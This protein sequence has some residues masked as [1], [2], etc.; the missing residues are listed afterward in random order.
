MTQITRWRCAAPL[1]LL[2]A[3]AP[4]ASVPPVRPMVSVGSAAA[5]L[6]AIAPVNGP[7]ALHVVYPSDKD[8]V[9]AADSDFIFGS[10]GSGNASLTING[11]PV[12]VWPNGAFLA[13]MA[14]PPDSVMHFRLAAKA[15]TDTASLDYVARRVVR[16]V[17][18]VSGPWIDTTAVE[19][20]GLLWW[21]RHEYLPI[22]VR[23]APGSSVRVVLPGGRV[24]PL[25]A[26]P[27][28]A[29]APWGTRAFD[30][31][32]LAVRLGTANDRYAGVVRGLALGNPGP[33]FGGSNKAG[34]AGRAGRAGTNGV[35]SPALP[36]LPAL[37]ASPASPAFIESTLG[38]DTVRVPWNISIGLLDTLPIVTELNDDTA[39]TGTTDSLTVG[40]QEPYGTYYWF[41]PTGTRAQVTARSNDEMRLQLSTGV[42]A[43]VNVADAQ[44]LP[45]GLPA[46]L[47]EAGSVRFVALADRVQL[48]IPVGTLAPF[49][50]DE[51]GH[52]LQ[53]T[54]FGVRGDVNW[55]QYGG[56]DPLI[57][58]ARW[59]APAADQVRFTIDLT[60]PVWGYRTRWEGT[61]LI[62]EIRRPP[63]I[64][65]AHPLRGR[66]IAIDPGH[67]PLGA[68]G[69]TGL[70]E[71]EANL[72]VALE[73]RR[74]LEAEGATV[75]MTRTTDTAIDLYPRVRFA[76]SVNAEM[77][78]SIHN[79]AF[80]DGVDP[81]L[82]AGT[83]SYYNQPQ[84]LPWV[85]ATQR[86]LAARL[87][88]RDLGFGRGDLALV[89]PT[90]MPAILT[91]GMFLMIPE[92]EN[93]LRTADGQHRYAEAVVDGMRAF[94]VERATEAG[95]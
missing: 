69:P 45:A 3:C 26:D 21:P 78:I 53:L 55:I 35:N 77:L 22:H 86:A 24:I 46:P 5:P 82:N 72:A 50:V 92:Q 81:F 75:L 15:G 43:W 7:L 40:R 68:K 90:W 93:A 60:D 27:R 83:S 9:D 25:V 52:R 57:A 19:P 70:R 76:D 95:R 71:P 54:L 63:V 28:P 14:F 61:D 10:T 16:F 32:T 88:I 56:V 74:L 48:R 30:R 89:R 84:S 12:R 91:E 4:H 34:E 85:R 33:L 62:F 17:P 65:A 29:A 11:T 80:P 2:A 20:H 47:G 36:A 13:W 42:D 51:D 6:P 59:D 39:N 1:A 66:R 58:G 18:P 23:A 41:F 79:N 49:H 37:P 94:L 8:L 64:D 31:D 87:G 73:V 38:A 44:P 67:P